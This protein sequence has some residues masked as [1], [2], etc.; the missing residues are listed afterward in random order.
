[1]AIDNLGNIIASGAG[2]FAK[3]NINSI[4]GSAFAISPTEVTATGSAGTARINAGRFEMTINNNL[5]TE[6]SLIYITPTSNTQNQVLYLLRQV[7]NE[8]FTVGIQSPTT[9]DIPFNW[10]I[11]N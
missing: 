10:I 4:V 7:P 5:V 9:A 11:V 8:S 3:L 1:M 2:S 6:K